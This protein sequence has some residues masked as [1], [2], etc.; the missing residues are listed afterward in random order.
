MNKLLNKTVKKVTLLSVLL[1]IVFAAALVLTAILGINY[2]KTASDANT[3]TVKVNN[4]YFNDETKLAAIETVCETELDELG[5]NYEQK[6]EMSGDESELVYYFDADVD[7]ADAKAA[8]STAFADKTKEGGEWDGAFISVTANVEVLQL[9]IPVS[10]FVRTGLAVLLFAVL[11]FGYTW[12]RYGLNGGIVACASALLGAVTT[13]SVLLLT[14]LPF[15]ASTLY[16]IAIASLIA[17]VVT[18][19]TLNKLRAKKKAEGESATTLETV[20]ES[21]AVKETAAL[22]V[23]LGVALVLTLALG[24]TAI[25]W[26]SVMSLIALVVSACIGLVFAPALYLPLQTAWEKRAESRPKNGYKGAKKTEKKEEV[27]ASEEN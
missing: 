9:H 5:V 16:V 27:V 22:T 14:R 24:T 25:R 2:G 15:T 4:F 1:A 18:L 3:L 21:T 20:V 6:G 19:F 26:F 7:L 8:L 11:A 17:T 23:A 13:A 10:Y 12:I